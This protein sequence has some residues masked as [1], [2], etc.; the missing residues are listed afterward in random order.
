M[1]ISINGTSGI[2]KTTLARALSSEIHLSFVPERFVDITRLRARLRASLGNIDEELRVSSELIDVSIDWLTTQGELLQRKESAVFD[3]S[4]FD[5]LELFL[6]ANF[7][8][9]GGKL[10]AWAVKE[11]RRQSSFYDLV[12]IPPLSEWSYEPSANEHGLKRVVSPAK[13]M[14]GQ[15]L[16]VGIIEQYCV[17]PRLYIDESCATTEQRVDFVINALK[18]LG[19]I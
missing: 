9:D 12:V 1:I 17:A 8:R 5:V 19:K 6:S 4:C 3:R 13:K 14:K 10:L 16:F 7:D 11:C 18:S 15:A 2:G